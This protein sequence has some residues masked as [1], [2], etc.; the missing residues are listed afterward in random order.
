M[1]IAGMTACQNTTQIPSIQKPKQ[2]EQQIIIEEEIPQKVNQDEQIQNEY[3]KQTKEQTQTRWLQRHNCLVCAFPVTA[4]A[5][6]R[7]PNCKS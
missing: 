4:G 1:L 7:S 6:R 3:H 2:T 5:D